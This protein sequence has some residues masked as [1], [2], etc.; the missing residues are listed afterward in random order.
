M[1]RLRLFSFA[2]SAP[3]ARPMFRTTSPSG[4][5]VSRSASPCSNTPMS[6]EQPKMLHV[7][8]SERLAKC[9]C[10]R[11]RILPGT[12]SPLRNCKEGQ[13]DWVIVRENSEGE[14]A[15]Q[16]GRSHQGYDHEVA[17]GKDVGLSIKP[18][19][20]SLLFPFPSIHTCRGLDLHTRCRPPNRSLRLP[21]R[22]VPTPQDVDLC[23]QV[24]VYILTRNR[25]GL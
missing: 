18:P 5:S 17:T 1:S 24:C 7:R 8:K 21:A 9:P 6:G 10:R 14:Y 16:G 22:S 2:A 25:Q 3:W 13:L 12:T 20:S 4:A 15:G 11:T 19:E 23:H